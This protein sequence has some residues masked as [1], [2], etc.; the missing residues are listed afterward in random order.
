M[1]W[2]KLKLDFRILGEHPEIGFRRISM[3]FS[4][5][6]SSI[7]E[8]HFCMQLS[9]GAESACSSAVSS[10]PKWVRHARKLDCMELELRISVLFQERFRDEATQLLL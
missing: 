8:S 4:I 9:S 7:S 6:S 5:V 2:N 1:N 10:L 3:D